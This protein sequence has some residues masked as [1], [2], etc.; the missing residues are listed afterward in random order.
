MRRIQYQIQVQGL[1]PQAPPAITVS[2]GSGT[3]AVP[4]KRGSIIY[5]TTTQVFGPLGLAPGPPLILV[6][7][8]TPTSD[9]KIPIFMGYDELLLIDSGLLNDA[10]YSINI[11]WLVQV[12]SQMGNA[13]TEGLA[14]TANVLCEIE[15]W[16]GQ[17]GGGNQNWQGAAGHAAV[18]GISISW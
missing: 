5:Q 10:N 7:D 6:P 11:P 9:G 13:Y 8:T 14:R 17:G 16:E 4:A 1:P 3:T 18:G 12:S 2:W 15:S